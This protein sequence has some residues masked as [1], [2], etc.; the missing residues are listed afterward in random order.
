MRARRNGRFSIIN[1]DCIMRTIQRCIDLLEVVKSAVYTRYFVPSGSAT[2]KWEGSGGF[3]N[4]AGWRIGKMEGI[5]ENKNAN[6]FT[7]SSRL[8]FFLAGGR[9]KF[10]S[11]WI[12]DPRYPLRGLRFLRSDFGF[13]Q[14]CFS[15]SYMHRPR[16]VS[17]LFHPSNQTKWNL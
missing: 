16:I 7:L 12:M 9:L 4:V 8:L 10:K 5:F 14:S 13:F 1:A 2:R 11:F 3:F 15:L 6:F 17:I